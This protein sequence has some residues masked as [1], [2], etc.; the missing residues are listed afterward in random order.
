MIADDENL[1]KI[2][3]QPSSL[4]LFRLSFG[5]RPSSV[6]MVRERSGV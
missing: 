2:V 3:A 6:A 4:K 5:S 1:G